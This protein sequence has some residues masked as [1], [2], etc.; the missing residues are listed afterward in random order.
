MLQLIGSCL[1]LCA[2][3]L[4]LPLPLLVPLLVDTGDHVTRAAAAVSI[5]GIG[6][7][8]LRLGGIV[9]LVLAFWQQFHR[10][11]N[12]RESTSATSA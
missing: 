10:T 8:L 11:E 3:L 5:V 7:E 2:S 9:C 12:H 6:I 4:Q 1:M